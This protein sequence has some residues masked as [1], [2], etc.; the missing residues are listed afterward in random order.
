[1][2]EFFSEWAALKDT[3]RFAS[4]FEMLVHS[5]KNKTKNPN[6]VISAVSGHGELEESIAILS[7]SHSCWQKA[8]YSNRS[9]CG[10]VYVL[11]NAGF[12]VRFYFPTPI[13]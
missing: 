12:Y 13:T 11:A 3:K 5:A 9:Q 6:F 8:P 7:L 1:V 2:R 4:Q 10:N